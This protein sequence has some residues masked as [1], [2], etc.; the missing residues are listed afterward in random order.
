MHRHATVGMLAE[1]S[2]FIADPTRTKKGDAAAQAKRSGVCH[3][4][5][6]RQDARMALR[7]FAPMAFLCGVATVALAAGRAVSIAAAAPD[8]GVVD[9][10]PVQNPM[11]PRATDTEP[12]VD[13][14][15]PRALDAGPAQPLSTPSP[16]V[17]ADAAEAAMV[18]VPA[19]I[20]DPPTPAA[21]TPPVL[22]GTVPGAD[23]DARTD[24]ALQKTATAAPTTSPALPSGFGFGG[25]PALNFDSD[26]G[27]G[28]GLIGTLYWYDGETRPYRLAVTLQLFLTSKLVQDHNVQVDWL[29]A[30]G[31]PLRL[32]MRI[33]YLQSLSQNYCGL[34]GDVTCDLDAAR[35]RGRAL[36]LRGA[37]LDTFARNYYQ[38]RFIT[39]YGVLNLRYSLFDRGAGPEPLRVQALVGYRGLYFIPGHW[40]DDDKDGSPDLYPYPNSLYA[41]DHPA[42]EPG[43]S[44]VV[45]AGI[46]VDTRDNEPAPTRGVFVE[47]SGRASSKLIGSSWDWLGAN[48]TAR[49]YASLNNS[50]S[51]VL[52]SRFAADA[53]LGDPPI[54][55]LVRMGGTVDY[56]AFGGVDMGR[57]I[58]TQ[59]YIGK[60]RLMNQT[61]LRWRFFET[62]VF[63][64]RFGFTA[65][66]LADSGVVGREL[67][68]P[69]PLP[70]NFGVGAGLRLSWNDNF[71]IRFDVAAS[72][73]ENF[74]PGVYVVVNNPF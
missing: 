47:A 46:I 11:Q 18:P 60:L 39:P 32:N 69:G 51:L 41:R 20:T 42:G 74:T 37:V 15:A 58:R 52:A 27:I 54:Q 8:A 19:V 48:I 2:F 57:G 28:F 7:R 25:V 53:V 21:T 61:E 6:S 56:Y 1:V 72:P 43:F 29:R 66:A 73:Q 59:R 62:E 3:W 70:I 55:E 33:G 35:A 40:F 12:A 17:D 71:V 38:R 10:D 45:Q 68:R 34:G 50:K 31:L 49:G 14:S 9:V 26:N 44:S 64:Q 16:T 23:P 5:L 24:N 63:A 22:D 67:A 36:G 65:V 13:G 30:F 4:T